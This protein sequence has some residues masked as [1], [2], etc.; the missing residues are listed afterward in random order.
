[1]D[2][3]TSGI[4]RQRLAALGLHGR[5]LDAAFD[6]TAAVIDPD[7][8]RIVVTGLGVAAPL[9]VGVAPFWQRMCAGESGVGLVQGLDIG[10]A[11]VRIAAQ[12]PDFVPQDFMDAKEARQLHG[13]PWRMH[14]S[15]SPTTTGIALGR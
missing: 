4:L 15:P 5:A 13:V 8:L 9:G 1:M 2:T 12:V 10:D 3:Y 7:D 11:A 6:A 14:N